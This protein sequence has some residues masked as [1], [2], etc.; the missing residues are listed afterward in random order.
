MLSS[1]EA[2]EEFQKK[3]LKIM[4]MIGTSVPPEVLQQIR[5]KET[6]S[7]MWAELCDL[8]EGKQ[9]EA[10]KAYTIRR[11]ENELW[12]TKLAPGRDANLH[13]C[14]IFS[15]KTEL[16]NLKH[17]VA[18]KTMVDLLLESLPDQIEVERLKSS[19][20]YGAD[21]SVYTPKRVRELILAAAAR[22]KE[23]RNRRNE[24]RGGKR[25][26]SG[27]GGE[28]DKGGD[29]QGNAGGSKKNRGC[30]FGGSDKHLRANCP[31]RA[32]KQEVTDDSE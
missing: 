14:M 24:K 6:G 21:P 7:E 1:A 26:G 11:L 2:K 18:D 31:E 13:I 27:K 32:K 25:G 29:Q 12:N 16:G 19:I 17:T 3:Q 23:F 15:L 8:Y 30:W 22:Q 9:N 28:Q 10:I 5:D 4:R 20:Y